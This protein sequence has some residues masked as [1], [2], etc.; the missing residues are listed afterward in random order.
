MFEHDGRC[1]DGQDAKC[2]ICR[3]DPLPPAF[4]ERLKAAD[5]QSGRAMTLDEFRAWLDDI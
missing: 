3:G 2:A 1:A 4:I 5:A